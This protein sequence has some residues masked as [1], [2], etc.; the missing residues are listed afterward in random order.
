VWESRSVR[1]L[2]SGLA[3]ASVLGRESASAS[4]RRGNHRL[5]TALRSDCPHATTFPLERPRREMTDGSR[6]SGVLG[7]RN[8]HFPA[9]RC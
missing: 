6:T 1:A 3:P 8:F 4:A 9:M 2:V 5:R 7:E